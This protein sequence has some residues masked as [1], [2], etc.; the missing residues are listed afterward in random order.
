MIMVGWSAVG[1]VHHNFMNP[2]REKMIVDSF[3]KCTK[4]CSILFLA[5]VSRKRSI[6]SHENSRLHIS[7]ITQKSYRIL[8][9]FSYLPNLLPT[10]YLFF[11]H[12]NNFF[13]QKCFKIQ[14]STEN[15][16]NDFIASKTKEFYVTAINKSDIV[17]FRTPHR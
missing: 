16:F 15:F 12:L 5:L 3:M 1:M 9:H 7:I 17:T 6:L 8:D 4:N 10:D 13:R 14:S 11:K 2:L